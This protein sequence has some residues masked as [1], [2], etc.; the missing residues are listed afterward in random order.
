MKLFR[1]NSRIICIKLLLVFLIQ[2][3]SP[4]VSFALTSGP[5]Q[6][7]VAG[8][9]PIGTSEMVN[10]FTG[11]FSY[12]IPLLDI[13]GYPINLVY[14][15]SVG[16]EDEASWVGLGWSLN[17]G[18][19]NRAMRGIPDDFGGENI[20]KIVN[21][22]PT[23]TVGLTGGF[24]T[25]FF[26]FDN[27]P[28][29]INANVGIYFNNYS[30]FGFEK[31]LSLAVNSGSKAR[32]PLNGS[33]G[34]SSDTQNGLTIQPSIGLQFKMSRTESSN[35]VLNTSLGTAWN[36]KGGLKQVSFTNSFDN[37]FKST[38]VGSGRVRGTF[39]TS[40]S[41]DLGTQT[42]QP[43]VTM[44]MQNVSYSGKYTT[45]GELFGLH[46]NVKISA[47][48]SSQELKQNSS[49]NP[50]YGYMY[51]ET[52][53]KRSD[54]ILDFNRENDA[55]YIP[56][57][58][59]LPLANF[60]ADLFSVTG[61]GAGGSYRAYRGDVGH[62]FDP[63]C[64][65]NGDGGDLGLEIGV[66]NLAHLG[67]SININWS[68]NNSNKWSAGN[69][70]Q[71]ALS[72]REEQ[73]N[74]LYESVYF[75]EANESGVD[76]DAS[77]LNAIGG[78]N[79]VGVSVGNSESS[80]SSSTTGV[81]AN[82]P[83]NLSASNRSERLKRL[84]SFSVL[85]WRQVQQGLGLYRWN[86]AASGMPQGIKDHHIA[87]ISTIG[88][89]GMSYI[90]ARPVMNT[91]QVEV[92]FA[93]GKGLTGN[94]IGLTP[95][96]ENLVSYSGTDNSTSNSRGLDNYYSRTTTPAYAYAY[97]LSA[98]LS[99]DYRD[100]DDVPG[101]SERDLGN[102]TLFEYRT[103]N[104]NYKW[105]SPMT[106]AEGGEGS[107]AVGKASYSSG[108]H[109]DP[110]DD[111][112]NYV[113]GEKEIVYLKHIKTRNYIAVFNYSP[114]EDA[115]GAV[116]EN[117]GKDPN[118]TQ[119]K[120]D[121]IDLYPRAQYEGG[122]AV[123]PIKSVLFSYSYEL[124]QNTVNATTGKLT[125]KR[126]WFEYQD[127][128]KGS[129]SPYEFYYDS[130]NPDY[131][132]L[133][134]DRWGQ[135]KPSTGDPQNPMFP[136]NTNAEF[137]YTSNDETTDIYAQS[138]L[139]S[140][141]RLP[142][143]GV[144]SWVYESDDYAFVQDKRVNEMF[145]IAGIGPDVGSGTPTLYQNNGT[146]V[147]IQPGDRFYFKMK[148]GY[149]N[150]NSYFD[151][152]SGPLYLRAYMNIKPSS[153]SPNSGFDYIPVYLDNYST[154]FVSN[155][156]LDGPGGQGP[157]NYG[158]ISCNAIPSGDLENSFAMHP[159]TLAAIQYGRSMAPTVVNADTGADLLGDNPSLGLQLLEELV[160]FIFT[161]NLATIFKNA[162]KARYDEGVGR[163]MLAE[164]S[165]LR[166]SSPS[167][168]KKGGGVRV[169]Q[170]VLNDYW[171]V[172]SGNNIEN[173]VYGQVYNYKLEDGTTSGVATYEPMLG[174]D[175][176]PFK[177]HAS[178]EID[179]KFA[180]DEKRLIQ[181]PIGESFYPSPSVGYSRV[182]VRNYVPAGVN[183][184][185]HA[186]GK[187]VQEFYTAKDFPVRVEATS[188][189]PAPAKSSI[190][191]IATLLNFNV[192]DNM[193]VGQG[194]RIE[195]NDMHGKQKAQYVYKE[196]NST[197]ISSVIY[198][199]Q[200]EVV[201]GRTVLDNK[202]KVLHSN[203]TI[204]EELIGVHIDMI[205]DSRETNSLSTGVGG[206]GNV[207]SFVF[208]LL[209][210]PIFI[211]ILYPS[212]TKE[213]TRFQSMST[214]K[215]VQRFGVLEEVIATD[216][217]SSVATKNIG[218]DALT[219]KVLVTET[220]NNYDKPVYNMTFPAH[221]Y[222][223]AMS[224]EQLSVGYETSVSC[225][226]E[227][228]ATISTSNFPF[229]VGDRVHASNL[230]NGE[231]G[232]YI[233][234][235][236]G[237]RIRLVLRNGAPLTGQHMIKILESGRTNQAT[238]AISQ[239]TLLE[240]PMTGYSV[241]IYDKV[242]NASAIEYKGYWETDCNCF[243]KDG[244]NLTSSNKY[245]M[246]IQGNWRPVRSYAYLTARDQSYQNNNTDIKKDGA[247]IGFNPFYFVSD[248][249]WR[250]NKN[251]WT[252]ASEIS[253]Y[254]HNGQEQENIDALGRLSAAHLGY[255]STLPVAVAANTGFN[256]MGFAHFEDYDQ[257]LGPLDCRDRMPFKGGSVVS[258]S[259]SGRKSIQVS[260]T[261]SARYRGK[262]WVDC[263]ELADGGSC[264]SSVLA[265][266]RRATITL[267]NV[268]LPLQIISVTGTNGFA[269][270]SIVDN[271][272]IAAWSSEP[273]TGTI[274]VS[275]ANGCVQ[276]INIIR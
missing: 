141:M 152:L 84:N 132:R 136:E 235:I 261:N 113:Y 256:Q 12:N 25:E 230:V 28:F 74:D 112:A 275:D 27:L 215:L 123:A 3:L 40:S 87:Q 144:I 232:V 171:N 229:A 163:Y 77:Y 161:N 190:T 145:E 41:F 49:S 85:T 252:F 53:E 111:K 231:Q 134:I 139:M 80:G 96:S 220:I 246:G 271:V 62:V 45:G 79:A 128:K 29:G 221:W 115:Y 174:G 91:T 242:L 93:V 203:G 60:T 178:V 126:V 187:V 24:N 26:G 165:F 260:Q 38:K 116:G 16:M 55:P 61:Q 255:N 102:Y 247:F 8:F 173:G 254:S 50:A 223:D 228:W 89:N 19:V 168:S 9:A 15:S 43:S 51:H 110:T 269:V 100:S 170:I 105:R 209:P 66:G 65:S 30:G 192:F 169:R 82:G 125:L 97:L 150:L 120:L 264:G 94:S 67:G 122:A 162:N 99:S 225:N 265:E 259:H 119:C 202:V 149:P 106:D 73:L 155:V 2:V 270:T 167:N 143:G 23:R 104:S 109:C 14:N 153:G 75:R 22:K 140:S 156:D 272:I 148:D 251:N 198:K 18:S 129:L 72:S 201:N 92:T 147:Q 36:S 32:G 182:E 248:G 179:V 154:N 205:S 54:A 227:G 151:D 226:T 158:Y 58:P 213:R 257:T 76:T 52:G 218:Y 189:S 47:Y 56:S 64:T 5:T 268:Q 180:P 164:K 48:Y 204:S 59:Y 266:P 166:L 184:S 131:N 20:E 31:G 81:T 267:S 237:N 160:E 33:L 68:E 1:K 63:S 273:V 206:N 130:P 212:F 262:V 175:E 186:T 42:Y 11:D 108:V 17:P 177:T 250:V 37:N 39:Q 172:M 7:E 245:L 71:G 142:S 274:V 95:D 146:P 236:Q 196:A 70:A 176:N 253:S 222:Y 35:N 217:T 114:R 117:G 107:S 243:T 234:E 10:V 207:D 185:R 233:D 101:P 241:N 193:A 138:W 98:V 183:L 34:F 88:E 157:A 103:Y 249:S 211:P 57:S 137:P 224:L 90:Y 181:T 239:I 135:Y 244:T 194:F 214:T 276:T 6:P 240:N 208:P 219:G 188:K 197:P 159:I 199:Y 216:N 46:G 127:S 238:A 78:L 191:S 69:G 118:Q 13:D 124:C 200:T 258:R 263:E 210:A 21:M 86:V 121:R 83:A 195:L 44:P 133:G 4:A